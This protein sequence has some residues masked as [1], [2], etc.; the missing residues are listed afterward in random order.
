MTMETGAIVVP[1]DWT[2][3]QLGTICTLQRGHDLPTNRRNPGEYPV[4]G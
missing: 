1:V 2:L 4:M 3:K